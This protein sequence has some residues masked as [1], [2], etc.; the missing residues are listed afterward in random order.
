MKKIFFFCLVFFS[1]AAAFGQSRLDAFLNGN[2]VSVY[3]VVKDVLGP[4]TILLEDD[5]V[6]D[7]IGLTVGETSRSR[8]SVKR[9]ENGFLVPAEPASFEIS[10]EDQAR[11]FIR[12]LVVG[13]K[14]KLEFD[15][16]KTNERQHTVAYVFREE[17][18]LF[19]NAEILRQGYAQLHIEPAHMRYA[20]Q[21]RQAYQEARRE[22]RGYMAD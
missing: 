15:S 10:W 20:D 18:N 22:Q 2:T 4:N 6:V 12:R 7:L 5:Q 14:V 8:N 13:K 17:D 21:L 16:E 19:I 9:D 3:Q 11:D 1:S